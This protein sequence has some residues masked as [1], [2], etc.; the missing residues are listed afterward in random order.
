[1]DIETRLEPAGE[2]EDL[3]DDVDVLAEDVDEIVKE[4]NLP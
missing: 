4:D 3:R 1:M 2:A